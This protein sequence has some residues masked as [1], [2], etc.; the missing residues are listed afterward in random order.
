MSSIKFNQAFH[1]YWRKVRKTLQY[2]IVILPV[3][4][5]RIIPLKMAYYI[6][7]H[8][9]EVAFWVAKKDRKRA[10]EQMK[11]SLKDEYSDDK[12]RKIALKMFQHFGKSFVEVIHLQRLDLNDFFE[13]VSSVGEEH[14][15]SAMLSGKGVILI[16]GHI[17]NWEYLAT[18]FAQKGYPLTV[19]ARENPVPG[20]DRLITKTRLRAGYRPLNRGTI[21]AVK[22]S[23]R[24]LKRGHCLGL[25]IDQDTNVDGVFV[26]FFDRT[27]WTPVGAASLALK[28][29]A[30]ILVISI[31]RDETDHHTVTIEPMRD[32]N[33]TGDSKID[34]ELVTQVLTNQLEEIIRKHPEQWVWLHQR[35]KTKPSKT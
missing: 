4:F 7:E 23:L 26:D 21:S 11:I 17:G 9:G 12:Y 33:L 16:T 27:A 28:T 19:L 25:L 6:G 14:I 20:F 1:N 35:W 18:Y 30:T 2:F 15:Q 10:I 5:L 3:W 31:Y 32:V 22:E 8:L 29:G 34:K 13:R 24:V